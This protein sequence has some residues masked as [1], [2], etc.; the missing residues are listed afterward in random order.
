LAVRL[1]VSAVSASGSG[2]NDFAGSNA[3]YGQ[4]GFGGS[5]GLEAAPVWPACGPGAPLSG[6]APALGVY[7]GAS[8]VQP[9]GWS[10]IGYLGGPR[11]GINFR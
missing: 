3:S 4:G 7:C 8:A 10:S 11:I 2:Q 1:F 6:P 9:Y 5:F